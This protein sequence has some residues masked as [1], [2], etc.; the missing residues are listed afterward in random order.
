MSSAAPITG[1]ENRLHVEHH[2]TLAELFDQALEQPL[3][4]VRAAFIAAAIRD[5]DLFS[6]DVP[7][8][9]SVPTLPYLG[10][11]MVAALLAGTGFGR[12]TQ[13]GHTSTL[14]LYRTP[15]RGS[16]RN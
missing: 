4:G 15:L 2:G 12:V 11:L 5:E 9:F 8:P 16:S 14:P 3:T 10:L 7:F 6:T 1:Y 13:S